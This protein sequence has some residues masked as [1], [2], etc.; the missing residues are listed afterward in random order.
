[1]VK[2]DK[3]EIEF[4]AKDL[5]TKVIAKIEKGVIKLDKQTVKSTKNMDKGFSKLANTISTAAGVAIAN[6]ASLVGRELV[7]QFKLGIT[8]ALEFEQSMV[9]LNQQV[10]DADE[11][12]QE[13]RLATRGL[14]SDLTL[15]QSANRALSFGLEK[16]AVPALAETALALGKIQ[17]LNADQA[18]NDIVTGIARASPLILDN[19]GIVLDAELTYRRYAESIGK[20]ATEL[21]KAEKLIALQNQTIANSRILVLRDAL[22]QRT[23]KE[24]LKSVTTELENQRRE[25][26]EKT[27]GFWQQLNYQVTR[28]NE[29]EAIARKEF[30]ATTGVLLENAQQ[31]GKLDEFYEIL[32]NVKEEITDNEKL[33]NEEIENANRLLNENYERYRLLGTQLDDYKTKL[34]DARTSLQNLLNEQTQDQVDNDERILQLKRDQLVVQKALTEAGVEDSSQISSAQISQVES[35]L[36]NYNDEND[37]NIQFQ[38]DI[39]EKINERIELL[40]Q[41][42]EL[43]ATEKRLIDLAKEEEIYKSLT[44]EELKRAQNIEDY[45]STLNKII[46]EDIPNWETNIANV[47]DEINTIN[48]ESEAI[49][50]KFVDMNENMRLTWVYARRLKQIIQTLDGAK[51]DVDIDVDLPDN[52]LE[53]TN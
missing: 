21:S 33:F 12:M 49:V 25:V 52:E 23:L 8:E 45:E 17:G 6:L 27:L 10:E 3:A 40:R 9:V 20:T 14:A 4:L 2:L 16:D 1:M 44:G 35:F 41:E 28:S 19:L 15:A 24:T 22:A 36:K 51:V 39:N 38:R 34:D 48:D 26:S 11:L 37:T 50:D 32:N 53:D 13:L 29:I 42:N 46:N 43:I 18:F 7:N 30:E 5:A 31:V 47:Q